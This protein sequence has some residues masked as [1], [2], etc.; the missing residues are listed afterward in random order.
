MH[1]IGLVTAATLLVV[2][3]AGATGT[4]AQVAG[5]TNGRIYACVNN[6]SGTIHII[7]PDSACAANELKLD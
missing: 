1:G 7:S 3:T 2:A 6:S 4:V 5:T